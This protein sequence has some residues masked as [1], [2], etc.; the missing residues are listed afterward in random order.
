MKHPFAHTAPRFVIV[1]VALFLIGSPAALA[2]V[3]EVPDNGGGTVD[4][5]PATC[6][7]YVSPQDLHIMIDGLP[8]GTTIRID[9]NH[10]EFFQVTRTPGGKF[11]PGGEVETFQSILCLEMEGTGLL[12]GFAKTV[13]L[14]MATEVHTG[15]RSPSDPVQTFPTEMVAMQSALFGD[16]DFDFLSVRAGSAFGLPSPGET[17]LTDLGGGTFAVDSFFDITYQI[18]FQGAPGSILEGFGG[19]T[20]ATVRMGAGEPADPPNPCIAV[21]DG[22]GTAVLPPPNCPYLSPQD[23]HIAIAGLPPDTTLIIDASHD[24]FLNIEKKPGGSLGGDVETFNSNGNFT[25]RGT[26]LLQGFVRQLTVP[27]AGEVH[28]GPR[29]SGDVQ[30]FPTEMVQLQGALFGDPDFDV[31]RITAGSGFGLPS[32]GQTTLTRRDNGT[33]SVDSFFD[34]TYQIEFVGTPGGQ[35]DGF[36][37]TTEDT[38]RMGTGAPPSDHCP[39][40]PG[41]D[42]AFP[43]TATL[44]VQPLG[45]EPV[46]VRLSSAGLPPTIVRHDT[47]VQKSVQTEILSMD[48]SGAHPSLGGDVRMN[49]SQGTR[50]QG[51][52]TDVTQ[53]PDDCSLTGGD[54]F[55]DVIVD[56]E[57]P[58]L[59]R[60]LSCDRPVHIFS[61]LT[62]L[63]PSP[64]PS[65]ESPFFD[66][67]NL[68][69]QLDGTI[70][71][72]LLYVRHEIDPPFPPPGNHCFDTTFE[73]DLDLGPIGLGRYPVQGGGSTTVLRT[74]I[75]SGTCDLSGLPCNGTLCPPGEICILGTST[76]EIATEITEAELFAAPLFGG[77]CSGL[78]QLPCITD[79]D[80]PDGET[81]QQTGSPVQVRIGRNFELPP[82]RGEV[83]SQSNVGT[84][85]AD[86]F[87]D[88]FFEVI[89][90]DQGLRLRNVQPL[91]LGS[92]GQDG[93]RNIPVDSGTVFQQLDP[94]EQIPLVLDDGQLGGFISNVR[95]GI[96]PPFDWQPPPPPDDY[97]FESWIHLR[98]TIY[99]PFCE[100]EV[101]LPG[102]FRVIRGGPQGIGAQIMKTLMAKMDFLGSS[103][104]TG[105]I[106]VQLDPDQL[107]DGEVVG[108]TTAEFFPASSFFD[109]RI[110]I[111]TALGL[112]T[113][114]APIT[115][116][117]MITAL[118]PDDGEIYFAPGTIIP[119]F[120]PTGL[121][122]GEILEVSHV[123][124]KTIECPPDHLSSVVVSHSDVGDPGGAEAVA[125]TIV[126]TPTLVGAGGG[127]L[128]DIVG[129]DDPGLLSAVCL[130][131]NGTGSVADPAPDPP[132]GGVRYY[133][134][135]ELF[136]DFVGS[137]NAGGAQVGDRD[138]G[139]APVCP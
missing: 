63:P 11:G 40:I 121:T 12:N 126:I 62:G 55:F 128:Y 124:H 24:R 18:D 90:E 132:V 113:P 10:N 31:F 45:Q 89:V 97:C 28:T 19:S 87:F 79:G 13:C 74:P 134:A 107:S 117:N 94:A 135:R 39:P 82:T 41:V 17:T 91:P 64:V 88:V 77:Q 33:W 114:A 14:Q 22:T 61:H 118:P 116:S 47:Q 102:T 69:D 9:A 125:A 29:G 59:G 105:P 80:C 21:D 46:V 43:T 81:C 20:T 104:C 3:C 68:I 65:Y 130:L 48:L 2:D 72:Q 71:G 8:A 76:E 6:S 50:S 56:I 49:L 36:S 127:I 53:D 93:I 70:W 120:D 110:Q 133:V 92:S 101:W 42:H 106:S 139:L 129:A 4:L 67:I 35:L 58:G 99:N 54:S 95:H 1:A 51:Q 75:Q 103:L 44:V 73:A 52:I 83:T 108:L 136:E 84:F 78:L 98:I 27:L 30:M 7:G 100:A 37:G 26:G 60:I 86:A 138:P 15:P 5:P 112:L 131:D 119:I 123:V 111:D 38:V 85:P 34:I 137:W 32:P 66:P 16:P 57:L 115:M 23:F 109:M 122:I 25:I 96:Q